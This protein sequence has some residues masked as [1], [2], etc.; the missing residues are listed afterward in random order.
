VS[1]IS[2]AF[3]TDDA[4][5]E[6]AEVG[7]A[8]YLITGDSDLLD[9]C[10]RASLSRIGFEVITASDFLRGSPS[11]KRSAAS[12]PPYKRS[13]TPQRWRL[14][15]GGLRAPG[16]RRSRTACASPIR[17]LELPGRKFLVGL[18]RLLAVSARSLCGVV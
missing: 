17:A 10:I 8:D 2:G 9:T 7:A 15:S 16:M 3:R 1:G 5:I 14:S 6:T 13:K 18:P 12:P 4:V 11:R